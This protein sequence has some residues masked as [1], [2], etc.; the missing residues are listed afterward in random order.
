MKQW[1]GMSRVRYRG[2]AGNARHLQFVATAMNTKRALVLMAQGLIGT[3]ARSRE[4]Q[5]RHQD[6]MRGAS[7]KTTDALLTPSTQPYLLHQTS[8]RQKPA[9]NLTSEKLSR[10]ILSDFPNPC[11]AARFRPNGRRSAAQKRG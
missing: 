1:Y 5:T 9:R 11:Y 10:Q 4:R 3:P 2:L 8:N 7:S 6:A